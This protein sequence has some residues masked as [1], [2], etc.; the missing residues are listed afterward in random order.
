MA[1]DRPIQFDMVRYG[2]IWSDM[3][4]SELPNTGIL[5]RSYSNIPFQSKCISQWKW[6][7]PHLSPQQ[8]KYFL[9]LPAHEANTN[10]ASSWSEDEKIMNQY[11]V[12][13]ICNYSILALF[14]IPNRRNDQKLWKH[15]KIDEVY[16]YLLNLP[17]ITRV[18]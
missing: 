17:N 12:V 7:V 8:G 6:K 3:V 1:L 10:I 11:R 5:K 15:L 2:P 14:H 9:V 13:E 18:A 4:H 16:S